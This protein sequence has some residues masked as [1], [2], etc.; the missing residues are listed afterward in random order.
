MDWL[1]LSNFG[2]V[3]GIIYFGMHIITW[4][5]RRRQAGRLLLNV[6]RLSDQ[7]W[8][9]IPS[10]FL[11]LTAIFYTYLLINNLVNNWL[12]AIVWITLAL[13]YLC[14]GL[15]GLELRENGLCYMLHVFKWSRLASYTWEGFKGATLT[16]RIKRRFQDYR[17]SRHWRLS[18]LIPL[19]HKKA[20]DQ[21]LTECLF[22]Y[23]ENI[24]INVQ[25]KLK[26][27][28]ARNIK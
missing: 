9:F 26:R 8:V 2:M 21:I 22:V 24:K 7:K 23:R 27:D 15:T 13:H 17:F 18:L 5:W 28:R 14:L 12:V 25:S 11:T 16:I 4:P 19:I 3:L 20:V 10:V 6:G 1:W